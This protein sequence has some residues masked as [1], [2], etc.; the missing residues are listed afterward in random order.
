MKRCTHC[1]KACVLLVFLLC[2]CMHDNRTRI[3]EFDAESRPAWF[4]RT[5]SPDDQYVYSVGVGREKLTES[6]AEEVAFLDACSKLAS[7]IGVDVANEVRRVESTSGAPNRS[8]HGS[9]TNDAGSGSALVSSAVAS[10][11]L[12]GA[13]RQEVFRQRVAVNPDRL[14]GAPVHADPEALRWDVYVLVAF[15][16][17][18]FSAL[19]SRV[20]QPATDETRFRTALEYLA[21]PEAS[22][23]GRGLRELEVLR[24]ANPTNEKYTYELGVAYLRFGR[25]EEAHAIFEGLVLS[26]QSEI[27]GLARGQLRQLERADANRKEAQATAVLETFFFESVSC[28][29]GLTPEQLSKF[30]QCFVDAGSKQ[31]SGANRLV[32]S[33]AVFEEPERIALNGS[34]SV[35]RGSM[36]AHVMWFRSD[37]SVEELH[38]AVTD[39]GAD[40]PALEDRLLRSL[41]TQ[42]FKSVHE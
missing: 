12:S 10:Q 19:Q 37:G 11:L 14:L 9:S 25:Q 29:S 30:Q 17:S 7:S 6:E 8:S 24:A 33:S 22:T 2:S 41:A 38:L 39:F 42:L 16:R 32:L 1:A 28:T 21:S 34:E 13:V 4:D 31:Q 15:P 35:L 5:P 18:E 40:G 3:D 23:R 20:R 26:S 27:R 36:T